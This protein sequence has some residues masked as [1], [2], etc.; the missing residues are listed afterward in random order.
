LSIF[1]FIVIFVLSTSLNN[2]HSM[3]SAAASA[4]NSEFGRNGVSSTAAVRT[5]KQLDFDLLG[6]DTQ[7]INNGVT[8]NSATN[9]GNNIKRVHL[10]S[11]V[12]R[13]LEE[14]D[15][16]RMEMEMERQRI[17]KKK[18]QSLSQN[19]LRADS[20]T[21]RDAQDKSNNNNNERQAA[22]RRPSFV[23]TQE[24]EQWERVMEQQRLQRK[25][26]V[27]GAS[28]SSSSAPSSCSSEQSAITERERWEREIELQK[29]LKK[30]PTLPTISPLT[31]KE[32]SNENS[33]DGNNSAA[34]MSSMRTGNIP[35][36]T[37]PTLLLTKSTP[38]L[39]TTRS[40]TTVAAK[41]RM[42][43]GLNT[44]N[45]SIKEISAG[46]IVSLPTSFESEDRLLRES[47][48]I[49]EAEMDERPSRQA[50]RLP[51]KHNNS[52]SQL[53]QTAVTGVAFSSLS[54]FSSTS[55]SEFAAPENNLTLLTRLLEA[56]RMLESEVDS[57]GNDHWSNHNSIDKLP[58]ERQ[59]TLPRYRR[60]SQCGN[61]ITGKYYQS[62]H[63]QLHVECV[64]NRICS[65]CE[66]FIEGSVVLANNT[67]WHPQV[68][69][70]EK[71]EVESSSHSLA[72]SSYSVFSMFFMSCGSE[73]HIPIQTC[74][75]AI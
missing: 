61:Q 67:F 2:I 3:L 16:E 50:P 10:H 24:R 33:N 32:S 25:Q 64:P 68:S 70:K 28:S 19:D 40:H 55:S 22:T 23:A 44:A 43:T 21:D 72:I 18:K 8:S 53:T 9:S 5:H 42:S 62:E 7:E 71:V 57:G 30:A 52:R 11:D 69:G 13:Q 60:C 41:K 15:R 17:E 36:R 14:A 29:R 6:N 47:C 39:A 31:Q 56:Q 4:R 27:Y 73:D 75:K 74:W 54:S 37:T 46:T 48:R 20:V 49:L 51:L 26:S 38:S 35:D 66:R 65:G 59:P 12:V 58:T 34:S 63:R 45:N 1:F